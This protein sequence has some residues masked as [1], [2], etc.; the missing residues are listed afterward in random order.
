MNRIIKFRAWDGKSMW[1]QG[2]PDLEVIQSFFFHVPE[3]AVLM[4]FTGLLDKNGKEIWEGDIVSGFEGRVTGQIA[5]STE[6]TAFWM[7]GGTLEKL[8][9]GEF[10][11][12]E[13]I[14]NFE[15]IGNTYS[16]PE[17]LTN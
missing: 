4:Q 13:Y 7:F 5:W 6:D 16:N 8:T 10:L 17:L 9:H 11:S 3:T 14:E 1:V 12:P 2:T 15:V